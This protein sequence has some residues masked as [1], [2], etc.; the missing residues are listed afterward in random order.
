MHFLGAIVAGA[1]LLSLCSSTPAPDGYVLHEKRGPMGFTSRA[2]GKRSTIN[3]YSVLPIRIGLTQ[4]DLHMGYD[5]VMD[6]SHPE[7]PNYGKHWTSAE[8]NKAFAPTAATVQAVRDWLINTGIEAKRITVS[9]N[10]GWLAFDATV[11]EAERLFHTQYYIHKYE[12]AQKYS[13]G[14][15]E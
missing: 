13:I 1:V 7:S 9:D 11:E 8:V 3:V 6:V 12:D 5:W 2:I 10:K 4:R 14:C 15:D